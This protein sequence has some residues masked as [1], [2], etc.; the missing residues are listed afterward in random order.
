MTPRI[1]N[2]T[3]HRFSEL[4]ARIGRHQTRAEGPTFTGPAFGLGCLKTW[5]PYLPG[6]QAASKIKYTRSLIDLHY[7]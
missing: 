3:N 4:H 1:V 2:K 5:L 6:A 7:N